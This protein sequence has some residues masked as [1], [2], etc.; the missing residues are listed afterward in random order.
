MALIALNE[1]TIA[2]DVLLGAVEMHSRMVA[3]HPESSRYRLN[4]SK[5][6]YALAKSQRRQGKYELAEQNSIRSEELA[7]SLCRSFPLVSD[8]EYQL[9][10]SQFEVAMVLMS[11]GRA[12]TAFEKL[13]IAEQHVRA[14]VGRADANFRLR[15][16]LFQVL[17]WKS[18]HLLKSEQNEL[19]APL[20]EECL[21]IARGRLDQDNSL[22]SSLDVARALKRMGWLHVNRNHHQQAVACLEEAARMSDELADESADEYGITEVL[23]FRVNCRRALAVERMYL[24]QFGSAADE[25]NLVVQWTGGKDDN[26]RVMQAF[27]LARSGSEEAWPCIREFSGIE[28]LDPVRVFNLACAAAVVVPTLSDPDQQRLAIDRTVGLLEYALEKD[29]FQA[30]S[31]VDGFLTNP[32]FQKL[33]GNPAFDELAGRI[34]SVHAVIE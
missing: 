8:F 1:N 21:T 31:K 14:S 15:H 9:G 25:W 28:R 3:D 13:D 4:L 27:S 29:Y 23:E 16:G 10:Y 26:A 18:F 32:S 5:T 24:G 20:L 11:L 34:K 7:A 2:E 19:A 6:F 30:E 33:A 12:G 22:S 17:M